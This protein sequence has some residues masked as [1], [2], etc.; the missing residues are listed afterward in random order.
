MNVFMT[1]RIKKNIKSMDMKFILG[2]SSS[3]WGCCCWSAISIC[4]Y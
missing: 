4:D 2:C 1:E 3:R